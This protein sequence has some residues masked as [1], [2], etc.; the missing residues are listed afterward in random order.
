M[1]PVLAAAVLALAVAPAAAHAEVAW[2][3]IFN[4]RDLSG[5]TPKINHH[6]AG[7]N[8]RDTFTVKDGVLVVSYGQYDRFNDEYGHLVFNTPLSAYRLRLEDVFTG[9]RAPGAQGWADRN[10]GVMRQGQ[11]AGAHP[12]G[13]FHRGCL[14]GCDG[15]LCEA[16]R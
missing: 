1:R 4:G 12:C 13:C 9:P 10:S 8:W 14:A 3:P 15:A 16:I 7:E 6:P 11:K 5:W 2:K